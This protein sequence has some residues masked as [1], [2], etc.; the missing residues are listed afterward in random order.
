MSDFKAKM[1][2]IIFRV[3]APEPTGELTALPDPSVGF[4]GHASKGVLVK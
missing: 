4:K 2:Q 1:H 3:S